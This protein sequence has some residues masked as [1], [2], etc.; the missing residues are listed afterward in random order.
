VVS[1]VV[2]A[3]ALLGQAGE[4]P[5]A[6]AAGQKAYNDRNYP[7]AVESFTRAREKCPQGRAVLL[8]LA[9]S[10][11]L[12]QKL[13]PSLETLEALLK[14]EP[15]N[16]E[17]LKLKGDV[18]YLLGKEGDA[19]NWLRSAID[20]EPKHTAARYALGRIYYQ[21]NRFP[22]AT[23]L[24]LALVQEDPKNYRAHDNLALCYAAVQQ[25]SDALKHFFKALDLVHKD[26]PEYDTVYANLANFMLDRREYE[27]AFQLA[28][29]AAKRNPG[30]SRNFFLTGKALVR[31]EK[32]EMSIRWFKRAAE[33]DPSYTESHYW[34]ATVYRTLGREEEAQHELELFRKLKETSGARR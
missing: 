8:P 11:L 1:V 28:A 2:L 15:R 9:Q 4:C 7:A 13:E 31:L 33:L 10:Q 5:S 27:K 21:Q 18:L 20:V 29:E 32:H 17:A 30:V 22:E 3:G 14:F 25:E 26:H 6:L 16:V 23:A 19:E 24:F 34:L 12:A